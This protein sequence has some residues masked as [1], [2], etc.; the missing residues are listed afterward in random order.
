MSDK[1]SKRLIRRDTFYLE[2]LHVDAAGAT[3]LLYTGKHGCDCGSYLAVLML[4]VAPNS[5]AA[6]ARRS[7]ISS[8]IAMP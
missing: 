7:A 8:L 2:G 4:E 5:V 3:H 6:V 1:C